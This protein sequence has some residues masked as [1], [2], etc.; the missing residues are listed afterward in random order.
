MDAELKYTVFNTK[1]GW[2]AIL[3]SVKG[4]KCVTLPQHTAEE[5]RQ[6][7]IGSLKHAS[8]SPSVFE[9]LVKR[10]RAY[11]EGEKVDFSDML[12]LQEASPFQLEVWQKTRLIPYGQTRSYAW[13]AEQIGK[14]KAMRGVG[15]A[16]S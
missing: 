2:M 3:W 16:L 10:L 1:A 13:V 8:L 6:L 14:P 7:L 12:D 9:D 11:F 5:A 4:L 15:H